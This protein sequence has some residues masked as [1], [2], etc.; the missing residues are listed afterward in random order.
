MNMFSMV[1]KKATCN[2]SMALCER[3][4]IRA[5][6]PLGIIVIPKVWRFR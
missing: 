4:R 2:E 5:Q 6:K 3:H 1:D